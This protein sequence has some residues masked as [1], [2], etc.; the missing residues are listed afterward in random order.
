VISAV[1]MDICHIGYNASLTLR[2]PSPISA[3][4]RISNISYRTSSTTWHSQTRN[5]FA[6][7]KPTFWNSLPFL[8]GKIPRW[9]LHWDAS[10]HRWFFYHWGPAVCSMH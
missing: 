1:D 5:C 7:Q 3:G 9:P 8:E 2:L 6:N 10:C 4:S